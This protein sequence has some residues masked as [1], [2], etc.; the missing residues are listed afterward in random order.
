MESEKKEI[1]I[2]I[3]IIVQVLPPENLRLWEEV[4]SIG[5][6]PILEVEKRSKQIRLKNYIMYSIPV[7]LVFLLS[8]VWLLIFEK[9]DWRYPAM[10]AHILIL[11]PSSAMW[12]YVCCQTKLVDRTPE[13]YKLEG[14]LERFRRDTRAPC[15]LLKGV[16]FL[17]KI[18]EMCT[19]EGVQ[20]WA[21]DMATNYVKAMEELRLVASRKTPNER[22]IRFISTMSD[23]AQLLF[24]DV[25]RFTD[26]FK[27]VSLHREILILMAEDRIDERSS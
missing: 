7:I 25:L 21:L 10:V 18:R 22:E 20:K 8:P 13:L 3:S 5:G 6:K 19:P 12:A 17:T 14:V 15:N 2:P 23:V 1:K 11:V 16:F 26:K 4:N 27:V 24:D 9:S